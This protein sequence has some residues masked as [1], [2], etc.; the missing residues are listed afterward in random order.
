M[1]K[2]NLKSRFAPSFR[3]GPYVYLLIIV[4]F[5]EAWFP[6]FSAAEIE[7]QVD[8][9]IFEGTSWQKLLPFY[10]VLVK[11][12]AGKLSSAPIL[13][14]DEGKASHYEKFIAQVRPNETLFVSERPLRPMEGGCTP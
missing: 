6:L 1:L 10:P 3:Y 4:L 8:L 14:Y 13:L 11:N 2:K 9:L 5:F 12:Q 7:E